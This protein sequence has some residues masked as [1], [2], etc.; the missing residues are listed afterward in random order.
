MA[1]KR[2]NHYYVLVMS[3]QGPK[4]VTKIGIRNTAYWDDKEKPMELTKNYAEGVAIGLTWNGNTA[5][6]V[7]SKYE[8]DRQPFRYELGEFEWKYNEEE[9][10]DEK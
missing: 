6:V 7:V 10:K 1:D 8:I 9:N 5:F 3:H 4:F 2:V